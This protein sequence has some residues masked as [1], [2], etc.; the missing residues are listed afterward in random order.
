MGKLI[1]LELYNFKSYK[2]HH[3]MHFGDSYFTS[4]IGPNG[5]GKSNSMDA[6]SFVLGIKSSH[7]RSSHLRD[8]VYRGR[9]LEQN[10]INADGDATA[11]GEQNGD[12]NGHDQEDSEPE[13]NGTQRSSGRNGDPTTAWVMAVYED[14]QGNEQQWKRSITSSGSSEYRI[15]NRQV[16]AIAYNA[17]LEEESILIKARNFLVFQGDVEAI[18]AQSAKDLTRLIE[19]ISGSLD[20]KKDYD[21]L[22]A[23]LERTAEVHNTKLQQRR[24]INSEI[25]QYQEQK[26]E[27]DNFAKKQDE[28]DE[29]VIAHVLW[30]LHH[31]Q[32][33]IEES[34]EE[35]QKYQDELKEFKR[36]I[37]D[38]EGQLEGARREQTA[39]KRDVDSAEKQIKRKEK[40]IE[41][42][43]NSVLPINEKVSLSQQK[44]EKFQSRIAVIAK[45]RDNYTKT[46][47]KLQKDLSS[48]QKAQSK[49]EQE[50]RTAQ[51]QTG[52]ELS[53][54]DLTQY[55]QLRAQVN[56][57]TAASQIEIDEITRQLKTDEET[58]K[59][60]QE[61]VTSG[62]N[63][64]SR[65]DDEINDLQSRQKDLNSSIRSMQRDVEAK[66][67]AFNTMQSERLRTQ[68]NR[69]EIEEKLQDVLRKLADARDSKQESEKDARMRDMVAQLKRLFTGV[70][71][72][73]WSLCKPKQKKYNVAVSTVLG[74]HHDAIV[75]DTEKTA[76]DCID[77]L[78]A[79]RAGQA[80]FI[81]LDTIMHQAPDANLKGMHP[82]MRLAVDTFEYDSA[83]E[84]AV[85]YACGNSI[86]CDTLQ[87]ARHLCYER[88]VDAKAVTLDGTVISKGGNMTGGQ[89]PDQRNARKFDDNEVDKLHQLKD[90]FMADIA[91]L[92]SAHSRQDE[93]DELQGELSGL[94][95]RRTFAEDELKHLNRN[96]ESK[97]REVQNARNQLEETEPKLA[98]QSQGLETM[99]TRLTT[100]TSAVS[101]VEDR[102][103]ADFCRRLRYPNIRAY[104]AQQGTMQQEASQKKLEFT[105]QISRLQGQLSF[106]QDR[107]TK[108][109]ERIARLEK[110]IS[111]AEADIATLEGEKQDLDS[112]LETLH[113][114]LNQLNET[115]E[116]RKETLSQRAEE[117]SKARREVEKRS[118]SMQST[119]KKVEALEEEISTANMARYNTLKTCLI[120]KIEIPLQRGSRPLSSLPHDAEEAEPDAMDIDEDPS[121]PRIPE[122]NDYGIVVNFD[123]LDDDL[124]ETP[125]D[126]YD[127]TE[128]QLKESID[129]LTAELEK[130]APH[131][132]ATERLENTENK[133]RDYESQYQTSLKD[134]NRAKSSFESVREKRDEL[135]S[136]AYEHIAAQIDSVYKELTSTTSFPLGGMASLSLEEDTEPYLGGTKYHA[137]PPLKRFRDMEHL[138]GGEKTMAALALLF[139][140][141][142][143]SPSPFFVLDEVDAALDV[144]NTSRLAEYVAKHARPGM[145]FV[146]ISLKAGLFQNS[147]TL[148]GVMRDQGI[149]SS[150]ALTLDLRKYQA[151]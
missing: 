119:I 124:K 144:A 103:F 67:K 63:Q 118:R 134:M 94:E 30:K 85:S 55:G 136:K 82:G 132:R 100:A 79:Q 39:A 35:I 76:K 11:D 145:Q 84:R 121:Q 148:V 62:Q 51:Q 45:D 130:M 101:T 58:V 3:V 139:A 125:S 37:A 78:K 6:I 112:T 77:Y 96:L 150:R 16:T 23:E 27:A 137:M 34:T 114:Q 47:D 46:V 80:T 38:Y 115:L 22:K 105:T 68:Q 61:K 20:Y 32:Q 70:R 92:P 72:Q 52:R 126:E 1:R 60:L 138:S 147:E 95:S 127:S 107:L 129:R 93:E 86:V 50:W 17:A 19:Q 21:D 15:N 109:N 36:G 142:T 74:R 7:L 31:F 2:N 90:K 110:E 106:E 53:E 66:K 33:T 26:R 128:R 13:E 122:A 123:S 149:N 64:V 25:K 40:E 116:A 141:H 98:E 133:L 75:V 113:G 111:D 9:V 89:G 71:G 151:A 5:S 29:A 57:E 88:R 91:A 4:I 18:A 117:V 28:R 120:E 24:S 49:W 73:L 59:S 54:A 97:K 43:E 41:E 140:I 87:I 102:V 14:D 48:V 146:V 69:R 10:K 143:F 65:L 135:F 12:A 104:E 99:R 131:A 8:L 42:T 108:T 56:R 44:I 81:P 83:I